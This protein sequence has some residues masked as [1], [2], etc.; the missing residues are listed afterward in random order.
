[1]AIAAKSQADAAEAQAKALKAS[2]RE[3][4]MLAVTARLSNENALNA[5]RPWLGAVSFNADPLEADKDGNATVVLINSGRGPARILSF[6]TS[7]QVFNK[8][9]TDPPYDSIPVWMQ[10]SQ[11]VLLPGMT[12]TSPFPYSRF[13]SAIMELVKSGQLTLYLYGTVEYEDLRVKDSRHTTKM[14][15][16]WTAD[17]VKD[18][19]FVNCPE[20][21]E[22]D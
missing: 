22:A 11:T 15:A 19:K 8:F 16:Y 2:V 5:D 21:N 9:P 18:V 20:Y 7:L 4:H 6:K 12:A 10:G 1:L 13:G 14:C 17:R 3:A